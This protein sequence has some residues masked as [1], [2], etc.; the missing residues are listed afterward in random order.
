MESDSA[1]ATGAHRGYAFGVF[2]M[3]IERAALYRRG[4]AV[5][6]RRQSFAV[7]HH[8]VERHGRL[9]RKEELLEAVWGDKSVT[10]DSLTHCLIDIRKAIGDTGRELIRTVPRQGFIFDLPVAPLP[11]SHSKHPYVAVAAFAVIL[12]GLT[13]GYF[14]AGDSGRTSDG[15]V[16]HVPRE[17]P[18]Q[19]AQAQAHARYLQGRFLFKRRAPGDLAAAAGYFAQAIELDPDLAAAWA[20]LAGQLLVSVGSGDSTDAAL[21]IRAK[22]AAER[23]VALDPGLAEGWMRLSGYYAWTDDQRAAD[24][25]MQRAVEADPSD[26]L[27]L[28]AAAGRHAASGDLERAIDLQRQAVLLEPLSYVDRDNLSI[29]LLAAG[30]YDEAAREN[31]Q[32]HLLHPRSD[33]ESDLVAAYLSIKLGRYRRALDIAERWEQGVDKDVVIAMASLASGNSQRAAPAILRLASAGSIE[34]YFR[35][36]ELE[37]FCEEVDRSF[38]WLTK[39]GKQLTEARN[40]MQVR[41]Y[42]RELQ[43]SPFMARLHGDPRWQEWLSEHAGECAPGRART[44]R[45]SVQAA[46]CC[47]DLLHS[48]VQPRFIAPPL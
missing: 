1:R 10:D 33:A 16:F 20:G 6:L 17:L 13:S 26:S 23:A 31:E 37:A 19:P 41:W 48:A 39:F 5:K 27:V 7:L 14:P 9:V 3:D 2:A 44:C 45:V 28:A 36:A 40:V 18:A 35:L 24:R 46:S 22:A 29:Y 30:R 21:L 11:S 32:A 43:L 8:L 12:L 47:Q 25:Y 38:G 4:K 15:A 34:A 42:L